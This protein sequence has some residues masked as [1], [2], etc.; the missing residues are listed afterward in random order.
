MNLYASKIDKL[1]SERGWSVYK[2]AQESEV[3][4]TTL[5]KWFHTKTAP[6]VAGIKQICDAFGITLAEFFAE[7]NL[8]ELT[9]D[10]KEL[11]DDFAKL[12][13]N[14]QLSVRSI[15]KSLIA[16]NGGGT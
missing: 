4:A 11:H 7:G 13:K 16:K 5:H 2:L 8:V 10:K 9:S 12:T 6:S 3:L 1:R 14:D 15:I